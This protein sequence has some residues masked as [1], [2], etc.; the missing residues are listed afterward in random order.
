[1]RAINCCREIRTVLLSSST[2]QVGDVITGFNQNTNQTD[3]VIVVK[4]M[5]DPNKTVVTKYSDKQYKKYKGC[6]K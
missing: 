6:T 3:K 5:K 4:R 2:V 1:M